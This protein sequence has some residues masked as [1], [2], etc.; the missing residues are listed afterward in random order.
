ME[1]AELRDILREGIAAVRSGDRARGRALLLRVVEAD[2]RV[3]PAWLWLSAAM[4]DPTDQLVA[5]ENVLA[6]NPEH[7][8]AL[9]GAQALRQKLGVAEPVS[10]DPLVM[11]APAPPEP[12][13]AA[14][15]ELH[16]VRV[17]GPPPAIHTYVAAI[18]EDDPYQCAYCGRQTEPEELLCPHCG[19]S[20]LTAGPWQGGAYLYVI[21]ILVGVHTQLAVLQAVGVYGFENSPRFAALLPGTEI[22]AANAIVPAIVRAVLW[23][24][25]VFVLLNESSWTYRL[26]LLIAAADLAWT[27]A[28]YALGYV[29]E[30]LAIVNM[31]ASGL[32]FSLAVL[33]MLSQTQARVRLKVSLD[34]NLQGAHFF[35]RHAAVYAR[36][37]K[38][39]LAAL[40]WRK[41]IALQPRL[42]AYY[43]AL[44]GAQAKLG[45]N[46]A[47]L[48]AWRSG[49]DLDPEDHDY[50]R[51]I[52]ALPK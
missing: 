18:P 10:P 42:P 25:A 41:A 33:S 36:E 37:G 45:R 38:W 13:P 28:G 31:A 35:D 7:T 16:P 32:V 40:H 48:R 30:L 2:E 47:A 50:A 49:A 12:V 44:G 23:A 4:D 27:G 8:Q 29:G 22:W 24:F 20:L 14:P 26:L 21:L 43:K 52:A 11:D 17:A 51:L 46:E 6:L 9:A 5:L 3:E 34:R 39:A 15:V 1:P 19:R